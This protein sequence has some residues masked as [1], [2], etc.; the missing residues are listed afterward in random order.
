MKLLLKQRF[1]SWFDSYDIYYED[2][3]V[4]FQ[5]KGEFSWGHLLRI[6]DG[7]GNSLA[8]VREKI[9]T[10]L[11]QFEIFCGDDYLGNI[12]KEL[13]FFRPKFYFD[14]NGWY[15]EGHFMEWDYEIYDGHN[16]LVANINKE[17]INF[18]DTY[19]IDVANPDDALL[20]LAFV[21]AMDA[22]K[23]SRND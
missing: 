1:F 22:E 16:N 21:L 8:A 9:I 12:H 23:C 4:A 3:S 17:V 11:P 7:M 15:V 14:F 19:S 2:G 6:Y 10:F 20:V 13:T 18:T 5:V